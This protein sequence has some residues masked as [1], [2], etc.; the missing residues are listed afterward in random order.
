MNKPKIS[1][2]GAEFESGFTVE[3]DENF[4]LFIDKQQYPSW[5][6]GEIGN[7]FEWE[8]KFTLRQQELQERKRNKRIAIAELEIR[9]RHEFWHQ[10]SFNPQIKTRF[11]REGIYI[12]D[13][14]YVGRSIHILNRIKQHVQQ[15]VTHRHSNKKLGDYIKKSLT[16][17]DNLN[18]QW[19]NCEATAINEAR[20]IKNMLSNGC[21]LLNCDFGMLS[22]LSNQQNT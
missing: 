3:F 12:I 7:R 4:N 9:D 2:H 5:V 15:A 16:S 6:L 19:V 21:K 22:L 18:V 14:I 1:I 17:G 8:R 11:K 20:H 10:V 13:E